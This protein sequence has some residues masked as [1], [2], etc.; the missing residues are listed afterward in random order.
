MRSWKEDYKPR[1]SSRVQILL[2]A[3]MWSV[4]GGGLFY[5]GAYWI[6]DGRPTPAGIALLLA[7]M[8][9]G[10]VKSRLVLDRTAARILTRIA[11][12]GEGRCVGGFLS[13]RSWLLV[14]GMII[15]GRLL[16][17]GLLPTAVAGVLYV[18][19]GTGL[20]ASSRIA[21]RVW[22]NKGQGS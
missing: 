19:I 1:A 14:L 3:A 21:W 11:S 8:G 12:R 10:I 18:A 2:A 13:V 17:G 6:T 5:V 15:L 9:A 4:V 16:R 7:G 20:L 22:F